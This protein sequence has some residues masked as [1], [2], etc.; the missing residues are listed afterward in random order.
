MC[1]A[2]ARPTKRRG[3]TV[4]GGGPAGQQPPSRRGRRAP[5]TASLQPLV[6]PHAAS[7]EPCLLCRVAISARRKSPRDQ[8][9]T[10]VSPS[11]R[12]VRSAHHASSETCRSPPRSACSP[13]MSRMCTPDRGVLPA[14]Q[15]GECARAI[16]R[17]GSRAAVELQMSQ[18]SQASPQCPSSCNSG[19]DRAENSGVGCGTEG[20]DTNSLIARILVCNAARAAAAAQPIAKVEGRAVRPAANRRTLSNAQA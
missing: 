20:I 14:A 15:C 3:R 18:F 17:S 19:N 11:H 8:R 6:C 4:F 5:Y 16:L 10:D 7:S 1:D 13:V 12:V 9:R 2:R